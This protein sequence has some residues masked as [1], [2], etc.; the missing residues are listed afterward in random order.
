L[1]KFYGAE[2]YGVSGQ[3][4]FRGNYINGKRDGF[5]ELFQ[6]NG[7]LWEKGNYTNEKRSG[8]W[9][10]NNMLINSKKIKFYL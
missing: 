4:S 2:Y 8:L 5:W 6:L 1:C 7:Q 9:I 10:E 3:L